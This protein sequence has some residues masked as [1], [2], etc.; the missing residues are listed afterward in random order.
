MSRGGAPGER[1]PRGAVRSARVECP[2]GVHQLPRRREAR[3]YLRRFNAVAPFPAELFIDPVKRTHKTLRLRYGVYRS[4]VTPIVKALG[5]GVPVAQ[6]L[7]GARPAGKLRLAETPGSR[8]AP[9]S[10]CPPPT[11]PTAPGAPISTWRAIRP[12][13]DPCAPS[14][15]RPASRLTARRTSTTSRRWESF[16]TIGEPGERRKITARTSSSARSRS[17][18]RSSE[19][20]GRCD[21]RR[22]IIFCFGFIFR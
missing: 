22:S 12:T 15:S 2:P 10:S 18:D 6:M 16:S 20:I 8:A 1:V 5:Q 21:G 14:S 19:R 7:E 11:I 13:T 17:D 9:P 4:I 3:E